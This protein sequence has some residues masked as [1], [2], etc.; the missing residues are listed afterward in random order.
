MIAGVT[1][2]ALAAVV[3]LRAWVD[4]ARVRAELRT[5]AAL[6]SVAGTA[7]LGT[8]LAMLGWAWAGIAALAIAA[9]VWA[10][11]LTPVLAHWRT[12]TDG[13]SLVLIVATESL[14]VLAAL[15]AASERADWLL[16]TALAP[17]VLGLAFYA[18]AIA[19]FDLR[20][21]AVGLGDQWIAGGAL[22]ISTL[23]AG[24]LLAGAKSLAI[25][26]RGRRD[27]EGRRAWVMGV[28]DVV[29]ARNGG[30]RAAPSPPALRR[31]PLVDRVPV[32]DVRGVHLRRRGRLRT[33][34]RITGFARVWV[35]IAVAVWTSCWRR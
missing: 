20:Q 12:P 33:S 3:P 18:F 1:W 5:P 10:L 23:A 16:V 6:T 28:D 32:R 26:G 2:L 9:V 17:F 25:L 30:R 11:L 22:A 4:R 19:R 35:W 15:L 14:A 21:L 13:S 7:V 29:V 34:A 31:A 24:K 27:P 8:R